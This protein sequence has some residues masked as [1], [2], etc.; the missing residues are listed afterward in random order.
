MPRIARS[1][2]WPDPDDVDKWAPIIIE[3]SQKDPD[4]FLRGENEGDFVRDMYQR[5]VNH[6]RPITE[7][8]AKWL[9]DIYGRM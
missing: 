5:V 9:W 2:T 3:I 4:G 6:R 8:Q 1:L 7:K